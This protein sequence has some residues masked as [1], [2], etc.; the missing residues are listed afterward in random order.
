MRK[1]RM[2]P[3]CSGSG[4]LRGDDIGK[5]GYPETPNEV[6]IC[7]GCGGDGK[8]YILEKKEPNLKSLI[9]LIKKIKAEGG[10]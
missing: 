7:H 4:E 2:C 6:R 8:V 9:K 3:V 1:T 10:K 5:Y